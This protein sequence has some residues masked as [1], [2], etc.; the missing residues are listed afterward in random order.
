[1]LLSLSHFA[2][3]LGSNLIIEPNVKYGTRARG[4]H[5]EIDHCRLF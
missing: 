2:I 3:S 5:I 4:S 1:M